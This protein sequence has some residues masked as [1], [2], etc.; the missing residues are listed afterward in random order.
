LSKH[1]YTH[2][3]LT[4]QHLLINLGWAMRAAV[5]LHEHRAAGS[6]TSLFFDVLAVPLDG[7][8]DLGEDAFNELAHKLGFACGED[9]V[10]RFVLLQHLPRAFAVF[11]R[12][13][14]VAS[15]LEITQIKLVLQAQLD[16]H[17]RL[18]AS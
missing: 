1:A 4:I 15:G 8:C 7:A 10:V 11:A 16:G 3:I 2:A 12:M 13:T 5:D 14:P 6:V 17:D 9:V 18:R